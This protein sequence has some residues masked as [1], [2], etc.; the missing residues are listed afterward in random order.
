MNAVEW[1]VLRFVH[2]CFVNQDALFGYAFIILIL[3]FV[4][5]DFSFNRKGQWKI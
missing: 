2:Y 3:L 4:V 5:I 1:H